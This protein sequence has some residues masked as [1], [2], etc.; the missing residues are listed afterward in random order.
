MSSADH[1]GRLEAGA[2]AAPKTGLV[3]CINER[4]FCC[5]QNGTHRDFLLAE[6]ADE[7]APDLACTAEYLSSIIPA[8]SSPIA[9]APRGAVQ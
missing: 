4:I 1:V 3:N 5:D 9:P 6:L 8:T 7:L 2:N